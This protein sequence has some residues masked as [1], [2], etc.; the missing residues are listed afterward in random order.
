MEFRLLGPLG[1][2][3]DGLE[4]PVGAG[5]LRA[6]LAALLLDEGHAVSTDQLIEALWSGRPPASATSSLH[7]HVLRLRRLMGSAGDTRIRAVP[8][9]YLIVVEPGELDVAVFDD[10]CAEGREALRTGAP[11]RARE[12]FSAALEL[13]RGEPLADV[14]G[15]DVHGARIQ[16]LV[17]AR[18]QALEARIE[19]DLQLARHHEVIGELRAMATE[20]P[21]RESVHGQLML[22]LYRADRQVE[23]LEVYQQLRR[24]LIEEL[25][26]EP[27]AS[28]QT[29]HGRILSADRAL[30]VPD[31]ASGQGPR[32][33]AAAGGGAD[34]P[35]AVAAADGIVRCN[36]PDDTRS[37]TGRLD[38][39][40]RVLAAAASAADGTDAGM[41]VISAIDGMGGVGKSA[42]AIHTGHRL[43]RRFPDWTVV[44]RPAGPHL[45]A[46]PAHRGRGAGGPAAPAGRRAGHGPARPGGSAGLLPDVPV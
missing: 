14:P 20:Q 25:G 27:C 43:R 13:W 39:V 40:D 22:A 36:L 12:L 46:R 35:S 34:A 24:A 16:H 37:F 45:R 44:H 15:A 2:V 7:N 23:A 8:A 29:L 33:A 5:K 3:Q 9:G 28:V 32:T 30:A 41:V 11:A 10:L 21:L 26:V 6:L 38:E 42:L 18:S 17:E 4:T 1:M 19:T 31:P